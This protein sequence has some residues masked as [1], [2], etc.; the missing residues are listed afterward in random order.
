MGTIKR[1]SPCEKKGDSKCAKNAELVLGLKE[2]MGTAEKLQLVRELTDGNRTVPKW[3][4]TDSTTILPERVINSAAIIIDDDPKYGLDGGDASRISIV[5]GVLGHHL[6][7]DIPIDPGTRQIEHDAAGVYVVQKDDPQNFLTHGKDSSTGRLANPIAAIEF[8]DGPDAPS[9]KL[10]S[11]VT[12]YADTVQLVARNGGINLYAGGVDP[13][14]SVGAPNREAAGINL[15]YGN[16][17]E[18]EDSDSPYSLE[19]MVKGKSLDNVLGD[20]TN[21]INNVNGTLFDVNLQLTQLQLA[22]AVHTH[23]VVAWG[24]GWSFPSIELALFILASSPMTIKSLLSNV[25]TQINDVLG[26]FNHSEITTASY[27]SRW[28]KVN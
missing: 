3:T 22:L 20:I 24:P 2:I 13:K 5:A 18:R 28:N 8:A 17:V 14:T 25:T 7:S 11:H 26:Q 9:D 27:K 6:R 10:K 4:P 19:P 16:K 15:I 1:I 23:P 21:Q 12:A